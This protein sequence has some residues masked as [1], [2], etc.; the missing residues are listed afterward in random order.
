MVLRAAREALL[1]FFSPI[2][3]APPGRPP[4]FQT[5][6]TP[7]PS[8]H[9]EFTPLLL[10][11]T[12]ASGR[13]SNPTHPMWKHFETF[14]VNQQPTY[15][16][17][18]PPAQG[19]FLALGQVVAGHPWFGAWLSAALMCG[20]ICWMLQGWLPPGWALLGGVLAALRLAFCIYLVKTALGGAAAAIGGCLVLGA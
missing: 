19:A 11:D 12:F 17:I 5:V 6:S 2:L 8:I 20:A 7:G 16:S 18:Y 1:A 10:A 13:L 14:H 15:G 3:P 4:M 9:A